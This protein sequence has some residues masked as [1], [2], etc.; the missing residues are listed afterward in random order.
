[1]RKYFN[2]NLKNA[3]CDGDLVEYFMGHTL[4]GSKPAYYE[5]NPEQ[6][7]EI[8]QK[9]IPF[10]TIR[11]DLD[12]SES[13]EYQNIKKENQILQA[14]T[15]RHVVER[16]ELADMKK[17]LDE[18]KAFNKVMQ[19]IMNSPEKREELSRLL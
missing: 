1:M 6:L 10:I 18:M 8:Y 15:A 17:E 7:K 13:P 11:K 12:I 3:G 9:F 5:G 19:A 4:D 16:S 2:S 14:E